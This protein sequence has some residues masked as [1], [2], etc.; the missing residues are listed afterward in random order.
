MFFKRE[1]SSVDRCIRSHTVSEKKAGDE[2]A[3]RILRP[4]TGETDRRRNETLVVG[5]A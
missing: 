5:P 3:D 1:H 2:I 4:G